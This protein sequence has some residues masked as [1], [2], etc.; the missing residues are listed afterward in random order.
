MSQGWVRLTLG[1]K[2]QGHKAWGEVKWFYAHNCFPFTPF[3]KKL[4]RHTPHE[5][6][7]GP[8]DLGVKK[9][10]VKVTMHRLGKMV[11]CA[12]VLPLYTYPHETSQAHSP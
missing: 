9:S 6:R 12:L 1:S 10:K 5:S 7:M 3:L 8:I 4:Q 2:G 11:S